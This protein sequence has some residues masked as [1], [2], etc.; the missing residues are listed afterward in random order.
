[1]R[2]TGHDNILTWL[3]LRMKRVSRTL[4]N[5]VSYSPLENEQILEEQ[6]NKFAT[7]RTG[8]NDLELVDDAALYANEKR[9][10]DYL[11]DET[12]PFEV[13]EKKADEYKILV[14]EI[15]SR[16]KTGRKNGRESDKGQP[17]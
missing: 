1:M 12:V 3:G 4:A 2:K 17:M 14:T 8:G 13:R 7:V 5:S 10:R 6:E 15:A 9:L 16:E 11:N